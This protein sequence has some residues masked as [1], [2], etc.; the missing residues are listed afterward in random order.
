M[1]GVSATAPAVREDGV[2]MITGGLGALGLEVAGWLADRGARRLALVTRRGL[3]AHAADA[4]TATRVQAVAALEA[5][6]VAVQVIEADVSDSEAMA[7]AIAAAGSGPSPLRGVIHT[8]AALASH[9]LDGM[10]AADVDAMLRPKATG[11][12]VLHQLTRDLPLDFFL[13]FSSTTGLLGSKG[14]GHYAAANTFL[15]ALAYHRR[16]AGL[17][18]VA[19]SWGVWEQIRLDSH[20]ER[21]IVEQSGLRPMPS[22]RALGALGALLQSERPHAIVASIDWSALVPVYEARRR[23][24]LFDRVRPA[25]A[26]RPRPG[27]QAVDD[28][29]QRLESADPRDRRDLLI[30]HLQRE[31]GRVLGLA[32]AEVDVEQ[33]VFDMGM[34]SLM[35]VEFKSRLERSLRHSLPTTLTFKYPT[36]IAIAD[37]LMGDVPGFDAA[38]AAAAAAP[39]PAPVAATAAPKAAGTPTPASALDQMSEDELATLLAEKLAGIRP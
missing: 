1:S 26:P 24:P 25:A 9:V 27:R 7:R 17:P 15:D 19:V 32:A 36:M 6:G 35:T 12:W 8:A 14:L 30:A 2:Y 22:T 33:G 21:R 34:D 29:R 38:A 20:A 13:M 16:A 4:R 37:F 23:R 11:A 5:R 39:D 31:A 3:A 28:A 18:A 10:T